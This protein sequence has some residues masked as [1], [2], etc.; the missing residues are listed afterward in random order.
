MGH[1][2]QNGLD[3]SAV[4]QVL[5]ERRRLDDKL[6]MQQKEL[7]EL[8]KLKDEQAKSQMHEQKVR[9]GEKPSDEARCLRAKQL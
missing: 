7:E 6:R 2:G 1:S 5:E 3:P 9:E 8:R 4:Q